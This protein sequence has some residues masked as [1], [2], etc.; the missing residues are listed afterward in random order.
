VNVIA[1]AEAWGKGP[2]ELTG[3]EETPGG[4]LK[5]FIRWQELERQKAI[6]EK[7]HDRSAR[8]HPQSHQ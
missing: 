5:W 3:E 7:H 8:N 1:A 2:W 6:R 4:K